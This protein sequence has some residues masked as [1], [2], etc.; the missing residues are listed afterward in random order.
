MAPRGR[1]E[2]SQRCLERP[3]LLWFYIALRLVSILLNENACLQLIFEFWLNN[4]YTS[5]LI[6]F[7]GADVVWGWD[8][9][10]RWVTNCGGNFVTCLVHESGKRKNCWCVYEHSLTFGDRGRVWSNLEGNR[11]QIWI[12]IF[13]TSWAWR[14]LIRCESSGQQRKLIRLIK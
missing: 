2:R 13:Q 11:L 14:G 7:H 8:V 5:T 6:G 1:S 3:Y 12:Q 4:L 9:L 10:W